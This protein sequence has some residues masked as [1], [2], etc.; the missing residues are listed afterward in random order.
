[1]LTH[2]DKIPPNVQETLDTIKQN[3]QRYVEIKVIKG[4]Y[5]VYRSTS[6]WDREE[7]KTKK[8]SEYLGVITPDGVFTKKK[9][10]KRIY[11]TSNEIFEYGNCALANDYIRDVKEILEDLTPHYREL[12]AAA[13]IKV[14]SPKPM[15][16]YSSQ[17]E[18]FYL[19]KTMDVHLS[20]KNI[21]SIFS[22]TGKDITL[23]KN[24]FS[25][26]T[27]KDDFLLYDLTAVF[28]YSKNLNLA[29]K[30]YNAHRKYLD[31]IGV[32]MA[33]STSDTIPVGIEVFF[34]SLKDIT[35]FYDFKE[36][37]PKSNVGFIFDRGFTSYILLE[38]LRDDDIHY[39]VP[40]KKNSK[41]IDLRWLRWKNAFQYRKRPIRWGKKKCDLG[42]LYYF[43]DPKIRGEEEAALLK[44]VESGKLTMKEFE[45][46]RKEAGIICLISDINR[47]GIKIFD[48]YKGR[49]DVE[50]AFDIMKHPLESDK[51]Y[52]QTPESIRGY[53]LITFL[54]MRIYFR[55]LRR[56]RE[57]NLTQ[58]ISVKE[59]FFELS[60]VQMISEKGG[61]EYFAKIP[62]QARRILSLFPEAKPMG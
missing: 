8:L 41:Y 39:I 16:L 38:E 20:P 30:S 55:V 31:Q 21:S 12:L 14:I 59:V 46:E 61:R 29:E 50:L 24:L 60:K 34:G 36:R 25:Q 57:K 49:E 3:E 40:L 5:C 23:W 58:K 6:I 54:A 7:K 9:S 4:R 53:F 10:R 35:T 19:S 37:F 44:R 48:Q 52:L 47:D 32:V 22:D 11:E 56:L 43:E 17:W 51:T 45:E 33:F 13:I 27:K 1:M 26:I 42:Y 28:T 18:K 2:M 15:R 62:K